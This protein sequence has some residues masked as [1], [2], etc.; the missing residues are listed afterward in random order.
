MTAEVYT[1]ICGNQSFII[2]KDAIVCSLC[3]EKWTLKYK[4]NDDPYAM[5]FPN[6]DI[7]NEMVK[8]APRK[9]N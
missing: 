8:E 5:Y 9:P 2:I 7:F 3:R 6:P 4:D 1:C